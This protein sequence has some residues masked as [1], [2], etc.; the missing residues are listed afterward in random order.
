MDLAYVVNSDNQEKRSESDSMRNKLGL[1]GALLLVLVLPTAVAARRGPPGSGNQA[2]G[3]FSESIATVPPD[4]TEEQRAALAGIERAYGEQLNKL[5]RKL[6]SKRLELQ[7]LFNNPRADE[8]TIRSRAKEVFELQGEC[9]Q[10]KFDYQMAVRSLLTPEQ[11]K[12]WC[13]SREG[14]LAKGWMREP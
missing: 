10:T 2:G 13:S 6:M 5:R 11:L 8:S 12:A 9:H 4:L 7:V 1:I 14:C 3:G